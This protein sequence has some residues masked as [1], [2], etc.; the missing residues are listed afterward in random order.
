MRHRTV[1]RDLLELLVVGVEAVAARRKP[2]P[3]FP[4]RDWTQL[5]H[6]SSSLEA[7]VEPKETGEAV[8]VGRVAEAWSDRADHHWAYAAS[9]GRKAERAE[10][11]CDRHIA[12]PSDHPASSSENL[13][14]QACPRQGEQIGL[15]PKAL[16]LDSKTE[17]STLLA[18]KISSEHHQGSVEP[19]PCRGSA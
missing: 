3:A 13:Y 15:V 11:A 9:N 5:D 19:T 7:L 10:V 12:Y 17:Q 1:L 8:V 6:A 18:T 14:H 16:L 2:Y 4:E